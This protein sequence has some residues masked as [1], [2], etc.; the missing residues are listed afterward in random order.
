MKEKPRF[1]CFYRK[2]SAFLCFFLLLPFFHSQVFKGDDTTLFIQKGTVLF[3]K[4][5]LS[6]S[7]S[8]IIKGEVFVSAHTII[9]FRENINNT[10]F[11][12]LSGT[13][14]R[15]SLTGLQKLTSESASKK[16]KIKQKTVKSHAEE[17]N[18]SSASENKSFKLLLSLAGGDIKTPS[19]YFPKF[20]LYYNIAY[21]VL[22]NQNPQNPDT[23]FMLSNTLT[24]HL[25]IRP[26]PLMITD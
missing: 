4:D 10:E 20:I 5:S 1:F 23:A 14:A 12:E 16:I 8:E 13:V 24:H 6:A 22:E 2:I 19:N 18:I 25:Y 11:T 9:S 3:S 21:T 15:V 17:T 26:P 7:S